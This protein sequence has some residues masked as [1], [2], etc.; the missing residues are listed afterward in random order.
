MKCPACHADNADKAKFCQDCGKPMPRACP[1]CGSSISPTAKFCSDCGAAAASLVPVSVK[2]AAASGVP[3][4]VKASPS[5]RGSGLSGSSSDAAPPSSP[6]PVSR[7]SDA[8]AERRQLTVMF[9][10]LVGST[11]LSARLDPEDLREVIGAYQ[12]A[13]QAAIAVYDGHVAQY[14]GDGLLVYFGYPRAQED[15]TRRS[16]HAALGVIERMTAE[17]RR[18]EREYGAKLSIRI[19]IHTGPA[20]VGVVGSGSAEELAIGETP[21]IA[22]RIQSLA[23]PDTVVL[24]GETAKLVRDAFVLEDLGAV[25]LKGFR[26]T[27]RLFRVRGPRGAERESAPS[28][29]RARAPL[30]GREGEVAALRALADQ[31]LRGEGRSALVRGDAGAGKSR[32]MRALRDAVV[33]SGGRYVESRC[34]PF[35]TNTAMRPIADMIGFVLAPHEEGNAIDL[36]RVE[37][38]LSRLGIPLEES[39]V[40]VAPLLGLAL[41]TASREARYVQPDLLPQARRAKTVQIVLQVLR[42]AAEEKPCVL[43]FEDLHWVDASTIEVLGALIEAARSSR[44]LVVMTSRPGFHTPWDVDSEISLSRLPRDAVERIIGQIAGKPLPEEVVRQIVLKADGN[45]LFAE[46]LSL[47]VLESGLLAEESDCYRPTLVP[48]PPLAIPTTLH[49]SLMARLD[50]LTPPHKALVQLCATIGRQVSYELLQEVVRSFEE[51]MTNELRRLTDGE[52]LYER[53]VAPLSMFVFRHAL[54]QD[55]AYGSLVRRTRTRYHARVADVLRERFPDTPA[56]V[57]AHHLTEAGRFEAAVA[58]WHAAGRTALGSF[59]L[60]E[61]VH[62]LLQGLAL[63]GQIADP[64]EAVVAEMSLRATL[65]VPFIFRHGFASKEVED[66]SSALLDLCTRA[67]SLSGGAQGSRGTEEQ[68]VAL[69]GL[70]Q[71]HEVSAR[72]DRAK[73]MGDLLMQLALRTGDSAIALAAHTSL[74][75]ALLMPGQLDQ[76]RRHFERGLALYDMARHK[77]LALWFGQDAGAMCAAFLSWVHGLDGNADEAKKRADQAMA[78]ADA[79]G[80]PGTRAFVETVLATWCCFDGNPARAERHSDVVVRLATEQ[81]MPH[82]EAQAQITRGWAMSERGEPGDSIA[83]MQRHTQALM[84][85]GA[86][87]STS[88][89]FAG[90][91]GAALAAGRLD[92][93][94]AVLAE[95]RAFVERSNERLYEAG[96]SILDAEL[97]LA[98][99]DSANGSA[100]SLA[101]ESLRRAIAVATQQGA[102]ALEQRAKERLVAIGG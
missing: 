21:N 89:Y 14:L 16:V 22:A 44:L 67:G 17:N 59:G 2:A 85:M 13:A 55:A 41:P 32:L 52:L 77:H 37:A 38:G 98:T 7:R 64:A 54:I 12:D 95:A 42:K 39:I 20:V 69:W 48:I 18:I 56:E 8:Q 5:G 100:K 81:G 74:G 47:M 68:L 96:L 4:S 99:G 66:N 49:D 101:S 15:S 3:V 62:H 92:E 93:A 29:E 83:L 65:N 26:G 87:A 61:A 58:E 33:E 60:A 86:R 45:P 80:Q 51:E 71:F 25:P 72:Y 50:R 19:G 24:S 10:D 30:V 102:G 35:F 1:S 82:W 75:A 88:F 73:D 79:L 9:C 78:M 53:G 94:R 97:A 11:E 46:E 63:I 31:A 40:Y 27:R 28:N 70:W 36:I 84:G 57:L 90:I 43:A 23:E 76:A 91:A 6:A 34:S